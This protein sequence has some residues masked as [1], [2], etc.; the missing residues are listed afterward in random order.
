MKLINYKNPKGFIAEFDNFF[1]NFF[2][3]DLTEFIGSDYFLSSP[4]TNIKET[5]EYYKIE[6]AAP[7]LETENFSLNLDQDVLTIEAK[8]E[9]KTANST[10]KFIRRE[11]NYTA[12]KRS[13]TLPESVDSEGIG[14]KY[15]HGILNITLPKKEEAKPLPARNIEIA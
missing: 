7:G 1:D 13:F 5:D 10:N 8:S 12:F 3:G 4:S 14:A 9:D 15:E 11:F 2:N 6:L